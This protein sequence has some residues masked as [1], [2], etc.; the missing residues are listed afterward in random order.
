MNTLLLILLLL[1]A[2]TS[3]AQ[4]LAVLTHGAANTEQFQAGCPT[5]WPAEFRDIGASTNLPA[6]CAATNGWAVWSTNKFET[7]KAALS[8]LK[9]AFN[10]AWNEK[11]GP[12]RTWTS[13]EFTERLDKFAHGALD[14]LDDAIA[15]AGLPADVRSQL[16]IARRRLL[17]AQEVNSKNSET[18]AFMAAAVALG[19]LT[20]DQAD[21][22]LKDP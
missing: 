7:T 18:V 1:A 11:N 12:G 16:R 10:K 5:N 14:A 8:A 4:N 13:L 3:S 15:N 19:I 6:G 2:L 9:E 21:H 17:A 22:V 20:Q